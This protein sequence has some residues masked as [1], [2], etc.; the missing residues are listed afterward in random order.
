MAMA[1]S[2]PPYEPDPFDL[3]IYTPKNLVPGARA[4]LLRDSSPVEIADIGV[5]P[6][7]GRVAQTPSSPLTRIC[8]AAIA[9]G[10]QLDEFP[11]LPTPAR[12]EEQSPIDS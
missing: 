4:A 3:G 12:H 7:R 9:E 2:S 5:S 6:T 1:T 10:Q 11:T 8:N